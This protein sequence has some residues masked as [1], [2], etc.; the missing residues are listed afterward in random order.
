MTTDNHQDDRNIANLNKQYPISKISGG[1]EDN[2]RDCSNAN[3]VNG[4]SNKKRL[5]LKQSK[6][7]KITSCHSP[8]TKNKDKFCSFDKVTSSST[9]TH[10]RA[11]IVKRYNKFKIQS[12]DIICE[13]PS[14]IVEL[15]HNNKAVSKSDSD[16][17][18]HR[19]KQSDELQL[20]TTIPLI[21]NSTINCVN[22]EEDSI[23]KMYCCPNQQQSMTMTERPQLRRQL[24]RIGENDQCDNTVSVSYMR[25]YEFPTIASKLK[26]V[27]KGY[28]RGFD[29]RTIPFCAARSTSPSHN[30]GLNIQQVMNIMKTRQPLNGISPTLAHN[31]GIAADKLHN[32]PLSAIVSTLSSKLG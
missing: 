9:T 22:I 17:S 5:R 12:K 16:D 2:A 30:I 14:R 31:I 3:I 1:E 15:Y 25:N 28:M 10:K 21:P 13:R 26:Q 32:N 18:C 27:A 4:Q 24:S 19:N 7:T 29:F 20:N 23:D 8:K 11:K 6:I